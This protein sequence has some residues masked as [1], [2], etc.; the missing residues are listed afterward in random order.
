MV[1]RIADEAA[2]FRPTTDVG[3]GDVVPVK[4]SKPPKSAVAHLYIDEW[5]EDLG[6][7]DEKVGERMGTSRTT[8]WRWRTEQ[9]RLNP[10][11]IADLAAGMGVDVCDLWRHPSRPSLD[12]LVK[13]LPD[14]EVRRMANAVRALL[15]TE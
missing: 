6:L 9:H 10:Q 2:V 11:K 12:S 3:G 14:A 1:T 5:M 15:K 4:R 13:D 7:T 8:V